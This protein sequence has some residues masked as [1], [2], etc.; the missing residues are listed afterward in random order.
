M[1]WVMLFHATDLGA[2]T[3]WLFLIRKLGFGGVD[4]FILLSAMGLAMSLGKRK[5]DYTSFMSRRASRVLPAYYVV[6]VPYT[7]FLIFQG[8]AV[9]STLIW[10]TTLLYDWVQ[11]IG[12]FN[13]YISSAMTFY[14]ITP[15]CFRAY[16]A[17]QP[18]T[19]EPGGRRGQSRR[20]LFVGTGVLISMAACQVLMHDGYWDRL[21]FMYRVPVFLIGLLL[22]FFVLEDRRLKPADIV[23]WCVWG[24]LGVGYLRVVGQGLSVGPLFF[25]LCYLFLFTTVPMCLILCLL[26][27]HLPLGWLRK[28]LRILG[29]YSLEIYLFNVT[30]FAET[31]L[32]RQLVP[33]GSINRIYYPLSFAANIILGI[34]LH[35]ILAFLPWHHPKHSKKEDPPKSAGPFLREERIQ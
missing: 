7:L 10:N 32:L 31:P 14:A 3:E 21:G 13:W 2:G 29:K 27:E 5:Q 24:L 9:W 17:L 19:E 26:F 20:L 4:I 12:A 18:A 23:F 6:M 33:F 35:H 34:A 1:F 16:A 22:G 25:P 28:L 8:R 11:P 15:M 30:L